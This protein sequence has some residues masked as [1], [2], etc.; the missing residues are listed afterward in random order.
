MAGLTLRQIDR[1]QGLTRKSFL[2]QYGYPGKPALITDI[3]QNWAAM[4]RWNPS[5]FKK[6][7]GNVMVKVRRSKIV[8]EEQTI[9]LSDYLDYFQNCTDEHPYYLNEWQFHRFDSRL[10]ADYHVPEYFESWLNRLPAAL[11]PDFRWMYIGPAKS[12]FRMHQDNLMTSAWNALISGQKRW[13]FYPPDQGRHLYFGEVDAFNPDS[14]KYP[15]FAQTCEPLECV[16]KAGE[17]VFTPSG[18][19]HQVLNEQ[20]GISITENFVNASNLEIAREA[21]LGRFPHFILKFHIPELFE[22]R[23]L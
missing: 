11:A 9:Q 12:W 6:R 15:L 3:T 23:P 5:L 14:E 16:Q 7:Y 8:H 20:P 22:N 19:W 17:V 1:V 21:I 18:W 10:C 4:E 2:L 13:L